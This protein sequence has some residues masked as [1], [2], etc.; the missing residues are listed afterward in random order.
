MYGSFAGN[1]ESSCGSVMEIQNG[2]LGTFAFLYTKL[3]F[4]VIGPDTA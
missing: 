3:F 2:K 4:V 1:E